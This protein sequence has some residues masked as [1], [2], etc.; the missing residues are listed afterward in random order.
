MFQP[1]FV[2]VKAKS[3]QVS[4]WSYKARCG[5]VGGQFGQAKDQISQGQGQ[6]LDNHNT[7]KQWV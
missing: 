1:D 4:D 3:N 2:K 5:Q 6:E 7:F